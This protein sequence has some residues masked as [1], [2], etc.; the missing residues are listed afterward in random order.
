MIDRRI[1]ICIN[2]K[3]NGI[4]LII[5]YDKLEKIIEDIL[6][7]FDELN[8]FNDYI[9]KG[10]TFTFFGLYTTYGDRIIISEAIRDD[11]KIILKIIDDAFILPIQKQA[12]DFPGD[13]I[14]LN[15]GGTRFTTTKTTLLSC[16]PDSIFYTM[17]GDSSNWLHRRDP[18]DNS[19]LIDRSG[20]YFAPILNYLRHGNLI[21]EDGI[22]LSGVYEEAKFYGI[23]SIMEE[24]QSKILGYNIEV[25]NKHI[26]NNRY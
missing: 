22:S 1:T 11:D 10:G 8:L 16:E 7:Q 13:W 23:T 15:I 25:C 2:G 4:L 14:I 26:I 9:K 19:I 17:F 18:K 20:K 3:P 5:K 21:I 12:I 6:K 24:L